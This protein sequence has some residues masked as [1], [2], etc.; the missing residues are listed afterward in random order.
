MEPYEFYE[1]FALRNCEDPRVLSWIANY[2]DEDLQWSY[3]QN[4]WNWKE[5]YD[6]ARLDRESPGWQIEL[7]SFAENV[8]VVELPQV[9]PEAAVEMHG[10]LGGDLLCYR[11]GN[12]HETFEIFCCTKD[13][14]GR[15]CYSVER[16]GWRQVYD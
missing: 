4:V 12:G 10:R 2:G 15:V 14:G 5:L 9:I 3:L 6:T 7:D 11:G 16:A 13:I 8:E 1:K